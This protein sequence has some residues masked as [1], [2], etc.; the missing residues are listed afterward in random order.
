MRT[1]DEQ[2]LDSLVDKVSQG[3]RYCTID[4]ELIRAIGQ[5]ELRDRRTLREAIKAT[6]SKLHQVGGAYLQGVPDYQ[7]WVGQLVELPIERD[8]PELKSFCLKAMRS[9]SSTRERLTILEHFYASIFKDLPAIHSVLDLACG[10]NPLALPWMPLTGSDR[11]LACDIFGDM[12]A[13]LGSFFAHL[14]QDGRAWSCDLSQGLPEESVDLVLLLKSIPCLE[15]LDRGLPLRLLEG[16][17]G[18]NV[19]TSFPVTSLGGAGKGMRSHYE[20]HFM[21]L[22]SG[23]KW[24][25]KRYE[26]SSELAFLVEK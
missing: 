23:K 9:H 26:F 4:R 2:D 6:R 14:H 17:N 3:E 24:K 21:E 20:S 10:L 11:Y 1:M 5:R 18:K 7:R 13:F 16:V 22:V 12:V 19:V 25:I 8:D 15:Q